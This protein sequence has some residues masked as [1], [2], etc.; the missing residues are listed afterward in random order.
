MRAL[1]LA[2]PGDTHAAH[3]VCALERRDLPTVRVAPADFPTRVTLTLAPG[4]GAT[5]AAL[6]GSFGLLELTR[7]GVAFSRPARPPEPASWSDDEAFREW[8]RSE[9][10]VVLEALGP[11]LE[12][13]WAP[14]TPQGIRAAGLKPTQLTEAASCGLTIP[15]TLVTNDPAAFARFYEETNGR[16]VSKTLQARRTDIDG[17]PR[18]AYTHRV[19]RRDATNLSALRNG[20]VLLQEAISKALEIRAT[21]A[22]GTVIAAEVDSQASMATREDWRRMTEPRLRWRPHALPP[23]VRDGLLRLHE[24]LGLRFSGTDLILT[25]D[26]EYVFLEANPGGDWLFVEDATGLAIT[27]AVADLMAGLAAR[28][29]S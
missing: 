24:R 11:L 3:L 13:R 6:T 10:R 22:G 27:D 8:T 19:S 17:V 23:A 15:R 12:G 28:H 2:D 26:G 29:E 1:L 14:A 25:P 21:V 7:V 16:M 18:F 9:S 5:D 4:R 20:P